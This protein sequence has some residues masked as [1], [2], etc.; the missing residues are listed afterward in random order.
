MFAQIIHDSASP[1][2]EVSIIVFFYESL[3]IA[4]PNYVLVSKFHD[5]CGLSLPSLREWL[6][7]EGRVS[8]DHLHIKRHARKRPALK[9]AVFDRVKI[10]LF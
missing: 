8:R 3:Q 9:R 5:E 10:V 2:E 6:G 7:R 4:F 1:K